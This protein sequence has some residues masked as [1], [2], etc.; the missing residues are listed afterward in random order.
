LDPKVADK[1]V[2]DAL[3]FHR[4][5]SSKGPSDDPPA[6]VDDGEDDEVVVAKPRGGAALASVPEGNETSVWSPYSGTVA[7]AN[8][9][10]MRPA[11]CWCR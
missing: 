1:A 3:D 6:P 5:G 7:S 4:I 11:C 10:S 9:C 2:E 8:W